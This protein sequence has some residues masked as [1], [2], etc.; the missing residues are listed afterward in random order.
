MPVPNHVIFG[1]SHDAKAEYNYGN[2]R[3]L[4]EPAQFEA[5]HFRIS[6][7]FNRQVI[8]LAIQEDGKKKVYSPF[9][10]FLL[11]CVG[12]E[13]LGRLY[14]GRE[15][16]EG[17][18]R[19]DVQREGFIKACSKLH[20]K[21]GRPLP[22]N[23]K[24]AFDEL[25]GDGQHQRITSLSVLVYK[26]GRHTM[27]H[28]YQARGVFLTEDLD[29]LEVDGGALV[30]NPYWFWCRYLDAFEGLWNDFT[31]IPDHDHPQKESMRK[32]RDDLL[33]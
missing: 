12:V 6:N 27:V 10:L 2:V 31:K 26:L 19:E 13:I 4:E 15:C 5:I 23:Q 33:C 16:Q 29:D 30:L 22:K 9:P 8:E 14:F 25:W 21:F 24:E 18:N 17:E 28:G 7:F 3:E 32:Y 11:G 20:Q 1:P